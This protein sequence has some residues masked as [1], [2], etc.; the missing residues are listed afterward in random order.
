MNQEKIA[1]LWKQILIEVGENPEREGMVD[2]PKRIAK[3]Y[4][5][6]FRGYDIKNKPNIT[7]FENGSDGL[8]YDEMITD[9]NN[10]ITMDYGVNM[11]RASFNEDMKEFNKLK[12]N[13]GKI[14]KFKKIINN[15]V[16][17]KYEYE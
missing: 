7:V 13:C 11:W 3:M 8:L 12:F 6:I 1:A 9:E 17:Y 16:K 4:A 10:P 5:E 14:I 2:T 15:R